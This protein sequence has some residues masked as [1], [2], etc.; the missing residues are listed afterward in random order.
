MKTEFLSPSA[1]AELLYVSEREL[2]ERVERGTGF[3]GEH[4]LSA[5]AVRSV[6]GVIRGYNVPVDVLKELFPHVDMELPPSLRRG[7]SK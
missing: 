1:L 6:A 5:W 3:C 7:E 4:D 2:I